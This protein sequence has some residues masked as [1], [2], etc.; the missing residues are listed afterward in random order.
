MASKMLPSGVGRANVF[1]F[2]SDLRRKSLF[3]LRID[4]V[5][6]ISGIGS[7]VGGTLLRGYLKEGDEL[8]VGPSQHGVFSKVKV[9]SLHRNRLP[10]T[11]VQSGQ[12]ACISV[13]NFDEFNLRREV[14]RQWFTSGMFGRRPG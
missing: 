14:F 7:I 10:C 9:L 5:Y 4:E 2:T 12:T 1:L 11:S 8:V 3:K 13:G 6:S